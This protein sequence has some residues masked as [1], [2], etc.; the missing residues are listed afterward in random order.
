MYLGPPRMLLHAPRLRR[1]PEVD[2]QEPTP[3][4]DPVE[5]TVVV[6]EPA[7][8]DHLGE[9]IGEPVSPQ[10]QNE[11]S[12]ELSVPDDP[13]ALVNDLDTEHFPM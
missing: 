10:P 11:A 12:D 7:V 3:Q 6:D 4:L 8:P 1:N 13:G 9:L 2:H 5:R